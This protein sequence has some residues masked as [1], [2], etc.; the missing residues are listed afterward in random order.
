MERMS[1]LLSWKKRT[2]MIEGFRQLDVRL[3]FLEEHLFLD[4]SAKQASA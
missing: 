4:Q 1:P 3:R 2:E